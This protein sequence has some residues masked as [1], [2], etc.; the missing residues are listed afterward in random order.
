MSC[1]KHWFKAKRKPA[2]AKTIDKAG[3]EIMGMRVWLS[4]IPCL[5]ALMRRR[6]TLTPQWQ[7][8]KLTPL[9]QG[10]SWERTVDQ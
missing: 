4:S 7:G 1:A 3:V 2:S 8:G 5:V 9:Q 6:R 10:K